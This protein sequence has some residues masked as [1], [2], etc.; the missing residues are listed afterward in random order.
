MKKNIRKN[1]STEDSLYIAGWCLIAGRLLVYLLLRLEIPAVRKLFMPCIL[2]NLTGLYCPG[3]GGTRAVFYLFQGHLFKSLLYHPFVPYAA[4][5][6]G[7]FMA[8]HTVERLSR[9]RVAV[10]M[11]YRDGY[12]WAAVAL[13]LINFIVKNLALIVW[14]VDLLRL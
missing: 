3:C 13:I 7:W 11:K 6:C 10:G 14:H 12:L 8:S 1:H 4:V 2:H 9:R 5:F